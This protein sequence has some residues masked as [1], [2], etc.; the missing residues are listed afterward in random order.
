MTYESTLD[1]LADPT[2]RALFESL[3]RRERPVGELAR[4]L[5][6]SQPAVS[7]HLG[8]LRR[9]KLVES[10]R[11]GTRHLYRAKPDGLM[12]L[13]AYVESLWD[14]VLAA[15]AGATPGPR[16]REAGTPTASARGAHAGT[17]GTTSTKGSRSTR[18]RG[19]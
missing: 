18:R 13:R 14:G 4:E 2:R 11:E 7:Q 19:R 17:R 6:I 15:Y 5:S 12:E 10:R 3:G 9:A 8:V 1:A 16:R